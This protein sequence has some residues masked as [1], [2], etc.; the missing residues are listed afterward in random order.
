MMRALHH[1]DLTVAIAQP[2]GHL[3]KLDPETHWP[4]LQG[5]CSRT[6]SQDPFARSPAYFAM[7]GRQGLWLY[8]KDDSAMLICRHPNREDRLLL[9]PPAGQNRMGLLSLALRDPQLPVGQ[10]QLARV[11]SN[12]HGLA[13]HLSGHSG[14]EIEDVLDWA[15]PVHVVSTSAIVHREGGRFNN[16][17][18]HVNRA[19]RAGL[20]SAPLRVG[21]HGDQIR[22]VVERWA[23]QKARPGFSRDDLIGPT[24]CCL[25]LMQRGL[26]KLGGVVVFDGV[27]AVGFWIWEE[28]GRQTAASLVRVSIG[29]HGAAEFGAAKAA[30]MLQERGITNFCLGGSE[31]E[32]L[33]AFKRK[34]APVHSV[35]L[36]TISL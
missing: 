5:H 29:Q 12:E 11:T 4:L 21:A 20:T 26:G 9:F 10:M 15:F 35:E 16:L 34:L 24:E 1:Y 6:I 31:T 23:D 27:Q 22:T 2:R 30:E 18:G 28:T 25:R 13:T 33:D 7:T 14:L 17:R 8:A 3:V 32:S 36:G 19:V